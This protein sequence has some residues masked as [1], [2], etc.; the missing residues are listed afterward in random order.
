MEL[1]GYG[2]NF[3]IALNMSLDQLKFYC[4]SNELFR[5]ICSNQEFWLQ[6]LQNEYPKI[7]QYKP[8]D[9][10]YG[11][12]YTI[13]AEDKMK[14]ILVTYHDHSIGSIPMFSTDDLKD[15]VKRVNDLSPISNY[16]CIGKVWLEFL[17]SS[18]RR[19]FEKD[20]IYAGTYPVLIKN[21]NSVHAVGLNS[22]LWDS[23]QTIEIVCY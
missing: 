16:Q 5:S 9:M 15:L 1:L 11:Q 3:N 20:G 4:T 14:I 10:S 2:P 8:F 17:R 22:S 23:L 21:T 19:D 13:L 12:Y 7:I 6:R 18:V